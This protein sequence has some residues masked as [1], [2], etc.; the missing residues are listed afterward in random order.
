MLFSKAFVFLFWAGSHSCDEV[1]LIGVSR[2][3][4]TRLE[5]VFAIY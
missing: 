4:Y 3:F 2:Q 1:D 5:R